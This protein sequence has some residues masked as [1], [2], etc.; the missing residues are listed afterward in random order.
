MTRL[1]AL[2]SNSVGASHQ[3][4]ASD[5]ILAVNS[6]STPEVQNK[7]QNLSNEL[8]VDASSSINDLSHNESNIPTAQSQCD[9]ES[10]PESTRLI[11]EAL[12]SFSS[13]RSQN[14]FVSNFDPSIHNIDVW[15][16]EVDRARIANNWQDSECL[17]RVAVCLRGDARTWLNEWVTQDRSWSNFVREFKPLCPRKL[18]YENILCETIT[19]NSDKFLTYAEYA[20][21]MLLRLR[22]VKGLSEELMV[23]LVIRGIT[24]PQ[25]RAAAANA[26][27]NSE[28]LV[29][30]LSIYTKPNRS[31]VDPRQIHGKKR[32]IHSQNNTLKC[33]NCG[34]IG[35]K[36]NVC[37]KKPKLDQNSSSSQKPFQNSESAN[38]SKV[39][40]NFCKKPGHAEDSCFAKDRARSQN[41]RNVNLCSERP[42]MDVK[43]T[44]VVTAV[45][46]GVPIDVCLR[47]SLVQQDYGSSHFS[48]RR[49]YPVPCSRDPRLLRERTRDSAYVSSSQPQSR[50]AVPRA[51]RR[52]APPQPPPACPSNSDCVV[53]SKRGDA[54]FTARAHS[55]RLLVSSGRC[56]RAPCAAR[57]TGSAIGQRCPATTK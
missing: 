26:N 21:R 20:R 11:V 54:V 37:P 8:L 18:D 22:I 24:D 32:P 1:C 43:N 13:S 48:Q 7:N 35:H 39:T 27:L 15:C 17:S 25:V 34:Q 52:D 19:I 53:H 23:S 28:D 42:K 31:K 3:D 30:F 40:C 44:D 36:S 41:K 10:L 9:V 49:A 33:F 14:Y 45:I 56:L 47:R 4:I 5:K 50:A 46:Q 51:A 16:E 57:R 6:Q 29:S 2:E 55:H 38:S 12:K